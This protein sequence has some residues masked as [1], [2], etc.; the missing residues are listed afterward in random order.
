MGSVVD[1]FLRE[2]EGQ[3][4]ER[5]VKLNVT[6]AARARLAE[7]GYDPVMGA[8]PL[9]RVRLEVIYSLQGPLAQVSWGALARDLAGRI[10]RNFAYNVDSV[11][12]GTT[13][14]EGGPLP[15]AALAW[16]ALKAWLS[17]LVRRS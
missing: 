2:L 7:L 14:A 17:G 12:R 1:K 16:A 5:K 11:L 9:T 8:R 15:V 4:A 3:L 13:P 6:P 10:T